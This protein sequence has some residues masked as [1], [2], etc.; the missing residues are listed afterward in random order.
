MQNSS[1]SIE[2]CGIYR[3]S[4]YDL[5]VPVYIFDSHNHALPAWG[6]ICSRIGKSLNLISFDTHNDTRAPFTRMICENGGN[7]DDGINDP[8][9]IQELRKYR[10]QPDVFLFEDVFR[11]S[12]MIA[13]DEQIKTAYDFGYR[14]FT[15]EPVSSGTG[16]SYTV[17]FEKGASVRDL[18]A[19]MQEYGLIR[20]ANLFYVQYLASDYRDHLEPGSYQLSTSMTAAEMME[21][22][23]KD[24]K[25]NSETS[26]AAESEAATE[27]KEAQGTQGE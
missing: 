26:E 24:S 22:M 3:E 15:E 13:N 6:T 17:T 7:P 2:D 4:F 5:G 19:T 1:Y 18:A 12:Y 10:Y 21:A 8:V 20:D 25:E 14:V 11:L 9:I 23:S 27:T 16:I